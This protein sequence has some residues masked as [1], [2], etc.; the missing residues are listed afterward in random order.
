MLFTS[1]GDM[2]WM[3]IIP[4]A[5]RYSALCS[6]AALTPV[7][8]HLCCRTLL[9]QW[10][11]EWDAPYLA[12]SDQLQFH[13]LTA[14]FWLDWLPSSMLAPFGLR[15]SHISA[16]SRARS[17]SDAVR[18]MVL[19]KF[20]GIYID[21]DVL[22]LQ[23]MEPFA[24]YEFLYEWSHVKRG[25]NSAV[26]GARPQSPFTMAVVHQAL[27]AAAKYD[28]TTG[29]VTFDALAFTGAFHP[30]FIMSRVPGAIA[31]QIVVLPSIPFDAI[32]LTIDAKKPYNLTAIH[33][34]RSWADFFVKPPGYLLPPSTPV[35]V[36]KGAY[37]YHWHN[38]WGAP[39]EKASLM[40]KLVAV[41]DG[42]LKDKQ[43]NIYGL[44][45]TL[46]APA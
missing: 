34:M 7:A 35:D 18:F 25:T 10:A 24:H 44:R 15:A 37:A 26:F 45:A 23:N 8:R 36:F 9:R 16:L 46:C 14:D 30:K 43:P 6:G 12:C 3:Q 21:G 27:Q 13:E 33:G 32:W 29:N 41:Y 17:Y 31:A 39:L 38:N 5:R 40:G 22:L 1:C 28:A 2:C 19:Y 4:K 20:G 42:F 11:K